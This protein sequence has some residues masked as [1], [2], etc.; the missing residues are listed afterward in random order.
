MND[1]AGMPAP[2]VPLPGESPEACVA[3]IGGMAETRRVSFGEGEMVWRIWGSG[4]PVV[5]LHGGYGAWSHWIRNVLPLSQHFQV[6]AGDLPAHGES[7]GVQGRPSRERM[8]EGLARC[9]DGVLPKEGAY[10]LVGFSMGANLSAATIAAY[11]RNPDHLVVVGPGGL[12]VL[13]QK[14]EGLQK[15]RPDLSRAELDAR[16]RN[17][18]SVI[19]IHDPS[20]IDDLAVHIQRE[21]GLRMRYH[22]T[23]TGATTMLRDFLPRVDTKLSCIWGAHDVYVIGNR[24]ERVAVMR[25]S[26]PDLRVEMIADAGHWVMYERPDAFNTALLGLL[27]E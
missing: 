16:H 1:F 19:M 2:T 12:G 4:R 27:R 11:G 24:D 25:Q 17:N 6:I 10:D 20:R 13:S 18:L 3:R 5:F 23:R 15:W 21:N 26:H 22:V 8:A 14:I 9:L 7:D